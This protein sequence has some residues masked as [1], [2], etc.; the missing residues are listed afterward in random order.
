M[1]QTLAMPKLGLTM[2]EGLV[3]EWRRAPGDSFAAGDVLVVI[4]TDKIAS[5]VEAPAAG[6]LQTILVANGQTV[7]VGTPLARW[8][9]E[10]G[11]GSADGTIPVPQAASV[12]LGSD[13]PAVTT[14]AVPTAVVT[15][16]P[17]TPRSTTP[18]Q[19]IIAT[20]YARRLAGERG[21][22]LEAVAGSGPGG[23]IRA[24]DVPMSAP[25]LA[26]AL[27]PT[28]PDAT[29]AFPA[30]GEHCL[31]AEVDAAALLDWQARLPAASQ[32]GLGSLVLYAAARVLAGFDATAACG[33]DAGPA[34]PASVAAQGLLA[35]RAA[36]RA[37]T[38]SAAVPG[39]GLLFTNAGRGGI[40][41]FAPAR[42]AG[43]SALLGLGSLCDGRVGLALRADPAHWP[44][45]DAAAYLERLRTGLEDPRTL[46]L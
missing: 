45:A 35:L 16:P 42:P 15:S 5:D 4:E 3:A 43:W 29:I 36:L 13:M 37:P 12:V 33:V 17:A 18:G 40:R 11:V 23:R 10:A 32:A 20:P 24:A 21:V 8:V 26:H 30:S 7:P 27:A 1:V 41:L 6:R 19:R 9:S 46:L 34:V 38:A 25:K 44:A 39:H 22:A 2:T 14:A 31:L 28:K